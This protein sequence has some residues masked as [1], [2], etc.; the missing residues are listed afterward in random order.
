MMETLKVFLVNARHV[1]QG[2]LGRRGTG[3]R[4]KPLG[5]IMRSQ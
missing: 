5:S 3:Q 1:M 4:G 2:S